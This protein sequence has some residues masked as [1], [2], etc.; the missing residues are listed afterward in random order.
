MGGN[1]LILGCYIK[2]MRA[3]RMV[4]GN[5]GMLEVADLGHSDFLHDSLRRQVDHGSKAIG[6]VK[7]KAAE[8]VPQASFGSLR[9]IPFVPKRLVEPPTISIQGQKS[10]ASS[11]Q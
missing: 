2:D 10:K 1:E 11:A 9:C 3:K 4:F 5:T 8:S 6:L 7:T